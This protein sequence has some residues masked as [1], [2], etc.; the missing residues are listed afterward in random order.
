MRRSFKAKKQKKASPNNMLAQ[1]QEM[2]QEMAEVQKELEEETVTVSS[3]GGAVTVVITGHQ[4]LQSIE[5]AEDLINPEDRDMLQDMLVAAVNAAIEQSQAM[6]AERMEG[7]TGGLGGGLQ[8]M[9][10]GLG[11]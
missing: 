11:L 9:L 10:G 7:V 1:M 2:Q 8:D 5:I 6:A 4:R 3:G